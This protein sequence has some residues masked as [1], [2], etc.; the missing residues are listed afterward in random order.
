MGDVNPTYMGRLNNTE[1]VSLLNELVRAERAGARICTLS[2]VHAPSLAATELLRK[3][4]SDE[5]R[6]CRA[7]IE[8]L[9][10]MR[11]DPNDGVSDFFEKCMAID[12]FYERMQL[13]NKGQYWVIKKVEY[14][15]PRVIDSR[16]QQRLR[17]I[18]DDHKAN[19]VN[20][21]TY[22]EFISNG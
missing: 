21:E 15:L 11:M 10:I 6:S 3:M 14:A 2:I 13:L 7:L 17:Q 19:V 22:L 18:L 1:L 9:T 8:C 5:A 12:D 16:I 20:L 4:Q